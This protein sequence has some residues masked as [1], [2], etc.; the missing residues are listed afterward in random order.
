MRVQTRFNLVYSFSLIKWLEILFLLCSIIYAD[1]DFEKPNSISG[2][3]CIGV[4][5]QV[6]SEGFLKEDSL[7][8]GDEGSRLRIFSPNSPCSFSLEISVPKRIQTKA[9]HFSSI[10]E[11]KPI[12]F[13]DQQGIVM[14]YKRLNISKVDQPYNPSMIKIKGGYLVAFRNDTGLKG[15]RK[16]SLA[17]ARLDTEF[18]QV[19]KTV[20]FRS[21]RNIS[22]DPRCVVVDGKLYL[23]YSHV[24][25]WGHYETYMAMASLDLPTLRLSGRHD[26]QYHPQRIE[27]NWVPFVAGSD[28]YFLYSLNPYK[29]L[30]ASG[31]SGAIEEL[32]I[33]AQSKALAWESKWGKISGGTPALLVNDEYLSFF[34]SSFWSHGIR[35]YVMGAYTFSKSYP[36]QLKRISQYPILFQKMYSTPMHPNV[37][38]RPRKEFRVVFPGGFVIAEEHQKEVIHLAFGENDSGLCVLTLDKNQLW[39]SLQ[40]IENQ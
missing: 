20:I 27:K 8:N 34:H 7:E 6:F 22:E 26:L 21:K 13:A 18:K 9:I 31:D 10:P 15:Q 37:W 25:T 36:F 5:S 29:I 28:I 23:L 30:K 14:K 2:G 1:Y 17:I 19:G 40:N 3:A 39:Q 11:L 33:Q 32:D 16:C 35:W 4:G 38:F 12:P 24:H